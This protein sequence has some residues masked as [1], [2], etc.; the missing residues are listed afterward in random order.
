MC[1]IRLVNKQ[2][3]KLKRAQ[4]KRREIKKQLRGLMGSELQSLLGLVL[5]LT[6]LVLKALSSPRL[7]PISS[8]ASWGRAGK[9]P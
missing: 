8:Q 5:K 3:N 2:T 1:Y 4:S 9:L 6:E 7:T